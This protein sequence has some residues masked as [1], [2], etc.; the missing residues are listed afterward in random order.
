[1]DNWDEWLERPREIRAARYDDA[2]DIYKCDL[3]KA[4][5]LSKKQINYFSEIFF[6]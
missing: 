1:M 3:I 5:F 4:I 6:T 2:D